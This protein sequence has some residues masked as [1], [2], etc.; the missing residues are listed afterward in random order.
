MPH[1]ERALRADAA[2][3]VQ[4]LLDAAR[5]VFAETGPD[6]PL[7]LIAERAGVGIRTLFRHF[8]HKEALVR[9][10]MKQAV[11][12]RLPPILYRTPDFPPRAAIMVVMEAALAIIDRERNT[13]AAAANP[14]ALAAEV[15]APVLE[16]L[17][18]LTEQAKQDGT[19]R[20]DVTGDD[21]ARVLGMLTNFL[22]VVPE[23]HEGWRRY[24]VLVLD[25][26]EPG[27]AT[28]LPPA[29]PVVDGDA[30]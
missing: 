22:W 9:T 11:T 28:P 14:A 19:M 18:A 29:A 6:A 17:A 2:R 25:A 24:L 1:E 20:S 23:G 4:R 12:E 27:A 10:A 5:A 3:N 15:V 21:V 16:P 30:I 8:P 26:F 7:E 13:L